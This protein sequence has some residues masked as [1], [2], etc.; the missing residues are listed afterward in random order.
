MPTLPPF[1]GMVRFSDDDA[2]A[3]REQVIGRDN[4]SLRIITAICTITL[5]S[6]FLVEL[7]LY[8][9]GIISSWPYRIGA[10]VVVTGLM[11]TSFVNWLRPFLHILVGVCV[12]V[13]VVLIALA[14]AREHGHYPFIVTGVWLVIFLLGM[15]SFSARTVALVIVMMAILPITAVSLSGGPRLSLATLALLG[16]SISA[17][18]LTMSYV[19]EQHW[20]R[21][22]RMDLRMARYHEE[23][24]RI[25]EELAAAYVKLKDTQAQ[26]IK[27]EKTA[28]L[29]RVVANVAHRINT[30][31]GN[32]VAVASHVDDSLRRLSDMITKGGLRRSELMAVVG[33][34]TEGNGIILN[35]VQR[36]AALIDM[37]KGLVAADGGEGLHPMDVRDFL[38]SVRP[39]LEAMLTPGLTLVVDAA[40]GL[41]I[42]GQ[43][44]I[45]EAIAGELVRNAVIHGFPNGRAGTVTIR[46]RAASDGDGTE[47][48]VIDDGRGMPAERVDNVFDPFYTDGSIGGGQ[49]LGLSIVHNSVVGS[50]GG[51]ITLESREGLGTSVTIRLPAPSS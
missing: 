18:T 15:L 38:I 2:V 25:H 13:A 35:N 5:F 48:Q 29:G 20:R 37:F 21:A 36:S 7:N 40:C 43:W 30:P 50:L 31:I 49:G 33:M 10:M 23:Q 4:V 22:F 34:V 16:V 39:S 24:R 12:V 51:R 44:H 3:Y 41:G 19:L 47:V 45:L 1:L 6:R 14:N 27:A 17:V 26:L 42:M 32:A 28:A 8:P 11:A 9:E 46:A